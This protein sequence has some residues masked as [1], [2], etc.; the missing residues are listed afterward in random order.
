MQVLTFDG[1]GVVMRKEGLREATRKRAEAS[2]SQVPRSGSEQPATQA[3]A[4]T[5]ASALSASSC[6]SKPSFV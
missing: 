1:K 4:A 3:P 5:F 2:A 6:S